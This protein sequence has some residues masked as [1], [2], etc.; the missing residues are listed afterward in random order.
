MKKKWS[1]IFSEVISYFLPICNK[2]CF[3]IFSYTKQFCT[4]FTY[5]FC[6]PLL[7]VSYGIRVRTLL[8]IGD[9]HTG[10]VSSLSSKPH[11][12]QQH[13]WLQG[14]NITSNSESRHTLH[15]VL[16]LNSLTTCSMS[17]K[18]PHKTKN[19]HNVIEMYE[20]NILYCSIIIKPI[21]NK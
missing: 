16:C 9:L 11:D 4:F 5:R 8:S 18:N 12:R 10:H 17:K 14:W 1:I 13:R 20:M 21:Q 15:F 6:I 3:F 2:H 7:Q 19:R